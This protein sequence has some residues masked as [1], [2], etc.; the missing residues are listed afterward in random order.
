MEKG[1]PVSKEHLTIASTRM[2]RSK[3]G[4]YFDKEEGTVL[5]GF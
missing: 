1:Y 2:I 4:Q 5:R 3:L